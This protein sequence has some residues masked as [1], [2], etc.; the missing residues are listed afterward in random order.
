MSGSLVLL[1]IFYTWNQV[2]DLLALVGEKGGDDMTLDD[3]GGN[4]R[5]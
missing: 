2:Q 3:N 5:E 4:L 1:L